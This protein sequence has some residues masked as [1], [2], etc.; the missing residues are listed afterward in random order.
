MALRSLEQERR[1]SDMYAETP[2]K[3]FSPETKGDKQSGLAYGIMD[4]VQMMT[5]D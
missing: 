2:P 1:H 3:Y 5:T 4:F